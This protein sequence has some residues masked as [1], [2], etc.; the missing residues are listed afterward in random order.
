M[1]IRGEIKEERPNPW[2]S[3]ENAA[4]EIKSSSVPVDYS[5]IVGNSRVLLL[6]EFHKNSPIRTHLSQHA[7]DL[8]AA[9]V[10]HYGIEAPQTEEVFDRLNR[11][12]NVDLSQVRVGPTM[13][14]NYEEAVRAIAKTG[15][16]IV[17]IDASNDG[18]G[19]DEREAQLTKNVM[20]I[21]EQDRDSRVAVLI[22]AQHISKQG[23][24]GVSSLRFRLDELDIPLTTVRFAGGIET[25]PTALLNAAA[26]AD[27]AQSEFMLDMS[28]YKDLDHVPFGKNDYDW[29]IH[30]PSEQSREPSI[31]I[32]KQSYVRTDWKKL[33]G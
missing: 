1:D 13:A 19:T 6:G 24:S 14:D 12:E 21:L 25:I 32:H 20:Q 8:K 5:K 18:L 2:V 28:S 29:I 30:L 22:G 11:G 27:Q 23:L 4:K 33:L 9:G 17:P 31:E 15:I 26:S 16:K 3:L 10:T 7:A